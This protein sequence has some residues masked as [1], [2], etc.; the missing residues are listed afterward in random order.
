MAGKRSKTADLDRLVPRTGDLV[1]RRDMTDPTEIVVRM[2]RDILTAR[3]GG[4][5]SGVAFVLTEAG[6]TWAQAARFGLDGQDLAL[7]PAFALRHAVDRGRDAEIEDAVATRLADDLASAPGEPSTG[8]MVTMLDH[9]G[10]AVARDQGAEDA[11]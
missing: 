2:A 11:A 4:N 8:D 3:R 10:A 6:W 7:T 5:E 1:D 9:I